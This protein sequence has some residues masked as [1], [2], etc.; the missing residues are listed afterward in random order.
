[1]LLAGGKLHQ[2]VPLAFNRRNSL[3][4][5]M[6]SAASGKVVN[7]CNCRR[8]SW[9]GQ[10]LKPQKVEHLPRETLSLVKTGGSGDRS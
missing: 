8:K 9:H 5:G 1:M 7:P 3:V 6:V 2:N 10:T 4:P